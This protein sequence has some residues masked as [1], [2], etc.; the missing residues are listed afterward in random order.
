MTP[1]DT[2]RNQVE[3]RR[4]TICKEARRECRV[5][6][7]WI[8]QL[9]KRLTDPVAKKTRAGTRHVHKLL[10]DMLPGDR[11]F[12]VAEVLA[13]LR[14][15]LPGR[16][17]DMAKARSYL[18]YLEADGRVR[19]TRRVHRTVYWAAAGVEVAAEPHGVRPMAE[20]AA[21]VLRDVGPLTM[22]ELVVALREQGYRAEEDPRK[23]MASLGVMLRKGRKFKRDGKRWTVAE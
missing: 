22:A 10:A 4:D 7:Q 2:L 15:A 19:R 6:L 13:Q 18:Q 12:T 20:V 14:H 21:E 8:T 5:L 16:R 9:E 3:K 17:L 23:T 1:F 11:E